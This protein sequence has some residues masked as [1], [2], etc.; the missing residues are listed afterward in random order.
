MLVQDAS[1]S[2][3]TWQWRKLMH[4]DQFP[5]RD[6]VSHLLKHFQKSTALEILSHGF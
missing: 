6:T 3:Q 5:R 4:L 2:R 1:V